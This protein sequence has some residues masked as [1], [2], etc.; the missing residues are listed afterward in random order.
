MRKGILLR[1]SKYCFVFLCLFFTAS[2][3]AQDAEIDIDK[4]RAKYKTQNEVIIWDE[5]KYVISEKRGRLKIVQDSYYESVILNEQG[6][7]NYKENFFESE[8]VP[9]MEYDA[10]TIS[11]DNVIVETDLVNTTGN[12]DGSIFF[13]DVR[14]VEVTY[15]ALEPGS[16]KIL[17]YTREFL[18]PNLLHRFMFKKR[19]PTEKLKFIIEFDNDIEVG[20]KLFN[21]DESLPLIFKEIKNNKTTIYSWELDT[22]ESYDFESGMP[23]LLFT[24]PHI[25]IFI[26]SYQD[27][28]EKIEVLGDVSLL[29]KYYSGFVSNLNQEIDETLKN[30][31]AE[32]TEGLVDEEGKIKAIYYWVK[33]NIKYVAYENGYEGFI[34]REATLICERKFGDCKDMA[35]IITAMCKSVG[36]ESVFL[37]WIGTRSLPYTYDELPTPASDNHMIAAYIKGD[38]IIYLDATDQK[39]RFGLPSSF[40]QGKEALIGI[41]K[42]NFLVKTVPIVSAVEN[43]EIHEASFQLDG[44]KI[45]GNG[46]VI[47][48][49]LSRTRILS[50]LNTLNSKRRFDGVKR[51]VLLG[52]NKFTL[53]DF[54]ELNVDER[55]L[56]YVINYDFSLENYIVSYDNEIYINLF[57]KPVILLDKLKD[58]RKHPFEIDNLSRYELEYSLKLNEG[59][60]VKNLPEDFSVDNELFYYKSFYT[61]E[62]GLVKLNYELVYRKLIVYS[63]SFDVWNQSIKDIRDNMKQTITIVKI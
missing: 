58:G 24:E 60:V 27:G 34:P 4:L 43:E 11:P 13:D 1:S 16:R 6:I 12:T 50:S 28:K 41:D 8:L 23:G 14:E 5:I 9:V 42:D 40:I 21:V 35:S 61:I 54:D 46:S 47:Y 45:F 38:D 36:V 55:D 19:F 29:Y 3:I 49:G 39:T 18:D 32:I 63:D 57:M 17:S 31:A 51:K 52:N 20:Y 56:P 37:T 2:I 10:Y 59:D 53:E 25:G 7:G 48:K 30:I 22:I 44:D 15:K 62:E 26:K 33:D